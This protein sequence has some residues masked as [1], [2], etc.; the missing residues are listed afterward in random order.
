M[1]SLG[2]LAGRFFFLVIILFSCQEDTSLLGFKRTQ[3]KFR[4]A[5][6]EI[7]IPA[8]VMLLDSVTTVNRGPSTQD[9]KRFLIG[10]YQDPKFGNLSSSAYFQFRPYAQRIT[11][12]EDAEINEI[13]LNLT[14]D[15]YYYGSKNVINQT[16]FVH[17]LIDTV[18]QGDLYNFNSVINY[19]PNPLGSTSSLLDVAEFETKFKDNTDASTTND[20]IDSLKIGLN[21][22]F[23]ERLLSLAKT[24]TQENSNYSDFL[25]FSGVFKGLAV[26]SFGG[27]KILGFDPRNDAKKTFSKVVLIYKYT[28]DGVEKRGRLDYALF[29]TDLGTAWGFSKIDADRSSTLLGIQAEPFKE[30]SPPDNLCYVQAGNPVVTKLDFSKF[31][32]YVDTIQNMILNSAEIVI[33]P[34]ETGTYP[35]PTTLELRVLGADN[36]LKKNADGVPSTY[37]GYVLFDIDNNL[38][39][40]SDSREPFT[41]RSATKDDLTKFSSFMT[42]F[43]QTMYRS[44]DEDDRFVN[45]AL[46]PRSP[47][48]GK[49]VNQ[50]IFK[51]SN[52][53]LKVYYT[54]PSLGNQ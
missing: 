14:Y 36:K 35:T 50:L 42:E 22:G 32:E 26:L 20:H 12:P 4:A 3:S 6:A 9:T 33:D 48:I 18:F 28:K 5:Y 53:K 34:I 44:K 49:S 2:R 40:I 30:F 27:N 39:M 51:K 37:N 1:N 38:N 19:D 31:Y 17:E 52:I 45:F 23:G 15:Y 43:A 25:K 46:V 29:S 13:Y 24:S 7:P 54:T 41:I 8:T 21:S 10:Q 47:D 16:L 11:I